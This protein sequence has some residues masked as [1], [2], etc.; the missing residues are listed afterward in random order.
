MVM[1][2]V[3]ALERADIQ[4][5]QHS[6]PDENHS[7]GGV[8]RS[9][10]SFSKCCQIFFII[11][12]QYCHN[13]TWTKTTA[14]MVSTGICCN[15]AQSYHGF[16]LQVPLPRYGLLLGRLF[17]RANSLKSCFHILIFAQVFVQLSIESICSS[18]FFKEPEMRKAVID[19]LTFAQVFLPP[20]KAYS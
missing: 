20:V 12:S 10:S 7:L 3:Q 14:W 4:F 18:I 5:V 8:S 19:I 2:N 1:T 6:Y 15:I 9:L 13:L 17:Q 11:F 16:T